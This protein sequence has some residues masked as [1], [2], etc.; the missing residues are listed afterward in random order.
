MNDSET[1]NS[2]LNGN[3]DDFK[4][5]VEKYQQRIFQIALGFVHD[6]EDAEDLSQEIFLNAWNSL[7][8]FRGNSSFSTWLHRIAVNA[9]LNQTRKS[10]GTILNR[11]SFLLEKGSIVISEIQMI[12]ENPEE[13]IIKKEHKEWLQRALDS[14]P[15]NQ[16]SA[17]VLSKYDDLSQKEIAEIMNLTEGAVEAL[18][19]RAKKN[20]REKLLSGSKMIGYERRKNLNY[21]SNEKRK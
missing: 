7:S 17:I 2:I 16:R 15:E 8:K 11:I 14:L 6:K 5:L 3:R 18:M 9:C 19:Q 13:I 21:V 20:L 4:I 12:D 10:K 1:I